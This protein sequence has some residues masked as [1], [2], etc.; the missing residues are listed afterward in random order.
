NVFLNCSKL[1]SVNVPNG[2]EKDTF[3]GIQVKKPDKPS[4]SNKPS[5][6]SKKAKK[7]GII[8][9]AVIGGLV[10][11]GIIA[12]IVVMFVKKRGFFANDTNSLNELTVVDVTRNV[13]EDSIQNVPTEECVNSSICDPFAEFFS[14][15]SASA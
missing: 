3:C 6:A 10:V 14:S 1:T 2:Y 8:A 15:S 5:N 11:V 4:N 9:G 12:V 13:C 7:A